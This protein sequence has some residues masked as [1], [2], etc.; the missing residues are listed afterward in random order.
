MTS[1]QNE[2]SWG[3][4]R[5]ESYSLKSNYMQWHC[6]VI[7]SATVPFSLLFAWRHQS[8]SNAA[9]VAETFYGDWCWVRSKDT[10]GSGHRCTRLV[11]FAAI[12]VT[13]SDTA[14]LKTLDPIKRIKLFVFSKIT[15]NQLKNG[16]LITF[17][18]PKIWSKLKCLQCPPTGLY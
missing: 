14:K 17:S 10:F 8:S 1:I 2:R 7:N 16:S 18:Q 13:G 5:N 4:E 9:L 15:N 3:N 12:V 11:L 6:I